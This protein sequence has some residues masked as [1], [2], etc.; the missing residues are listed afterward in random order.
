MLKYLLFTLLIVGVH[1][2]SKVEHQEYNSGCHGQIGGH[3]SSSYHYNLLNGDSMCCG[4]KELCCVKGKSVCCCSPNDRTNCWCSTDGCE[5]S[6]A[7]DYND[8]YLTE[9]KIDK[10]MSVA[11]ASYVCN[12][13]AYGK[14]CCCDT[15]SCQCTVDF[16]PQ[17]FNLV[18]TPEICN[19]CFQNQEC[20][21]DQTGQCMC[22]YGVCPGKYTLQG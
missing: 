11:N 1:S 22:V 12:S 19:S 21:C 3:C 2:L 4:K 14:K 18:G 7:H 9:R 10:I 6:I 17:N 13:C 5:N 15:I 8:N 16:C 20:C